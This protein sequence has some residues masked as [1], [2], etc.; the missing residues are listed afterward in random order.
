M[1]AVTKVSSSELFQAA[2]DKAEILIE[3]DRMEE[4]NQ[5]YLSLIPDADLS[6]ADCFVLGNTFFSMDAELA[7]KYHLRALKSLPEEPLTN[8]EY[9]IDL[10]RAGKP[11]EAIPYYQKFVTLNEGNHLAHTLLADCLVREG[12]L[13][14]AVKQ[15]NLANHRSNHTGIDF[16]IHTIYGKDSP[17]KR[18]HTL[19]KA[20]QNGEADK[21]DELMS[22]SASWDRDWWN[23]KTKKPFLERDIKLAQELL[24]ASPRHLAELELYA[25]TYL[26]E[27]MD[28]AWLREKLNAKGWI[29]G[30]NGNLPTRGFVAD[31]MVALILKHDLEKPEVLVKRFEE[32]LRRRSLSPETKDVMALNMLASLFVEL[33]GSRQ[34]DLAAV[35][36]AG[37]DK[38]Q[39]ERFAASLLFSLM[40]RGEL[41]TNSPLFQRAQREFP[42]NEVIGIL[43]VQMAEKERQPMTPFLMEAIKG[44]FRHL[45]ISRGVIKDSYMLKAL[46][47]RLEKELGTL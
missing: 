18:R 6:P 44:E 8:L 9:A 45:S 20:I 33:K 28:G 21:L 36:Q 25:E 27:G 29:L 46:F 19:L 14:A 34:A 38:Y 24:K 22:L 23:A 4:A 15:W 10:H 30:E 17:Y 42:E 47:A 5:V 11:L 32:E 40:N 1:D 39:D 13:E 3:E 16:A 2:G 31:R 7:E 35:D 41:K 43:G 26:H 12:K 37:W